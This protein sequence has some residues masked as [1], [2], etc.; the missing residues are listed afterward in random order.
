MEM[1]EFVKS[2]VDTIREMGVNEMSTSYVLDGYTVRVY[3]DKDDKQ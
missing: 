2:M 1:K 3:V